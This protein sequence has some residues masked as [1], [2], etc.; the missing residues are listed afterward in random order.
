MYAYLRVCVCVCVWMVWQ[1]R[2]VKQVGFTLSQRTFFGLNPDPDPDP[3]PDLDLDPDLDPDL[4]LD[5]E[6]VRRAKEARAPEIELHQD[7]RMKIFFI[8]VAIK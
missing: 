7:R 5:P 6:H 1:Q 3:D 4:D 2:E 8:L